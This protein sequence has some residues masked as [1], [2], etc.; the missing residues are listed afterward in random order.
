M[1]G[2]NPRA[3]VAFVALEPSSGGNRTTKDHGTTDHDKPIPASYSEAEYWSDEYLEAK[4]DEP[5][6]K[7]LRSVAGHAGLSLDEIYFTNT[8]KCHNIEG[9]SDE[10]EEANDIAWSKCQAYLQPELDY[11]D[12]D[13]I[14]PIGGK[15]V[16]A[17][18][19]SLGVYVTSKL[20]ESALT[21]TDST[22]KLI[23]SYHWSNQAK[24]TAQSKLDMTW[25]GKVRNRSGSVDW[26]ESLR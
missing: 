12:P 5:F 25:G 22:P 14:V 19:K 10:V 6:L 2:G 13:V 18:R 8:K 7:F 3:D 24:Q 4:S 17:V 23:P 26:R 15:A 21:V 1:T 20:K 9:D 11:V 16:K